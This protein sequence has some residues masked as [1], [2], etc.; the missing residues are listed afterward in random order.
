M[1]L[2][3][4]ERVVERDLLLGG[5]KGRLPGDCLKVSCCS[6]LADDLVVSNFKHVYFIPSLA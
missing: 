1:A 4:V 5:N 2:A 6:V 3:M